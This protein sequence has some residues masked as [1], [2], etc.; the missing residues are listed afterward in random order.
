MAKEGKT[1]TIYSPKGGVGKTIISLNLAGVAATLGYKVLL[2]DLS[3]HTGVLSMIIN[4]NI[5]THSYFRF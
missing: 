4:E 5:E 1:L 2:L 3:M